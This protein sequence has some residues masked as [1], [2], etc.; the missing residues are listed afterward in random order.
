MR[1]LL[2]L[3][4]AVLTVATAQAQSGVGNVR[5]W[6]LPERADGWPGGGWLVSEDST[7][8]PSHP[9]ATLM[10]LAILRHDEF[11][12]PFTVE[13]S[14]G[15][16]DFEGV[17]MGLYRL[18]IAAPGFEVWEAEIYVLSDSETVINVVLRRAAASAE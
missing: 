1:F 18:R 15:S 6:V 9:A 16:Y 14:D 11:P 17:P 4:L 2:A 8:Q 3:V 13:A 10:P 7:R 5:G 12:D